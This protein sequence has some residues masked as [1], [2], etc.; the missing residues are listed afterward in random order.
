MNNAAKDSDS[1][2]DSDEKTPP[3]GE[4]ARREEGHGRATEA[5]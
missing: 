5:E 3:R 1:D 2:A 4:A